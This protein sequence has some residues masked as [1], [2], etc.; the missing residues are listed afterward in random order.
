MSKALGSG[1]IWGI[2]AAAVSASPA[3]ASTDGLFGASSTGTVAISA[4]VPG[5]VMLTKLSDVTFN[6][7]DPTVAAT[8]AQD[9]CVWSNTVGRQY[10]I[11]ATGSGASDAFTLAASGN[12]VPYSVEWAQ[13]SGKSAGTALSAGVALTSQASGAVTQNCGGG[14]SASL[15]LGI[16]SDD[17]QTM[18][19]STAYT[20]TLTLVVSAQ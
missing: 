18:T 20:G 12:T 11:K 15:I 1:W 17:L 10:T 6:V 13:T 8:K 4:T 19:A 5:R 16:S 2:A 14:A 3:I 7:I 9:V